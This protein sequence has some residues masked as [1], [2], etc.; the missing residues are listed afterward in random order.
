MSTAAKAYGGALYSL[1]CEKGCTDE[2]LAG[3]ELAAELFANN[4]R[5]LSLMKNPSVST[6]EHLALL[7]EAFRGSIHSYALNFVKILCEKYAL[8]LLGS[9]IDEYRA[10]LYKDRGI[11]PVTAY[12]AVPLSESQQDALTRRLGDTTGKTIILECR[13]DTSLIGG[14]KLCYDGQQLDGSIAGRLASLR[15]A[16]MQ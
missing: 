13:I 6:R 14:I 5:Y 9:C 2:V 10:L 4:P 11:L 15:Q 7:D 12:S 16:L 3:V 1:A 8:E